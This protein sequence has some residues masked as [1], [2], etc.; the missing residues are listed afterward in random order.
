MCQVKVLKRGQRGVDT[1][2]VVDL[3]NQW[4]IIAWWEHSSTNELEIELFMQLSSTYLL[5]SPR[6][7]ES[8]PFTWKTA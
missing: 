8:F 7:I 5:L 3:E 2:R 6:I 1:L 4:E